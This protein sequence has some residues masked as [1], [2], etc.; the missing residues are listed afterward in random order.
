[1]AAALAMVFELT[2]SA[3]A[4]RRA[5]TTPRPV[6]LVRNGARFERGVLVEREQA[7]AA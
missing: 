2:G 4:R 7:V 3:L 5:I 6:A 1:M